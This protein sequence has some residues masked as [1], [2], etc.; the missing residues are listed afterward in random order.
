MQ[1]FL[2]E[3][4]EM[5]AKLFD[6][7]GKDLIPKFM[8]FAEDFLTNKRGDLRHNPT[9]NSCMV[10]ITGTKNSKCVQDVKIIHRW[11]G[12]RPAI[13]YLL[14]PFRRWLINEKIERRKYSDKTARPPNG[15]FK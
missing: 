1:G 14:R 12:Q 11:D 8:Q 13:N 10:R 5:L 4:E 9:V 3:E 7:G 2:L 15:S 6:P